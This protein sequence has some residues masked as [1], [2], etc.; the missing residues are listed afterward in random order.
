MKKWRNYI[1]SYGLV[2]QHKSLG[3]DAG[4]SLN[5]TCAAVVLHCLSRPTPRF[6]PVLSRLMVKAHLLDGNGV[7][8][9]HNDESKW[10]SDWDRGSRD[11]YTPLLIMLG[12]ARDEYDLT[13]LFKSHARRL[14]LC[15]T[16][17]RRNFVYASEAE[18]I[19][20]NPP[21]SGVVWDYSRKVPDLTGPEYWALYIRG[22]EA[23][24]LYPLLYL[25]DIQTLLGSIVLRFQ[26]N[27]DDVINHAL[28]LE[29]AKAR[30]DTF[31][32]KLAR[33]I[34]PSPFLQA[35]LDSFFGPDIEPPINEL[36]RKVSK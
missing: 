35:K 5:R 20:K 3:G 4:D 10:Y 32:M 2:T 7:V 14:F 21:D 1:D 18:T 8:R 30:M 28:T 15:A 17:T 25:F 22:F 36:Y 13:K 31:I 12:L 24:L 9:R 29:Y 26:K 34:N 33:L 27:K 19:A 23:K 16:N 6:G 11:Q